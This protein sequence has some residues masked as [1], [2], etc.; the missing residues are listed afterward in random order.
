MT[1]K[2]IYYKSF[3]KVKNIKDINKTTV[4]LPNIVEND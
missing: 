3:Y 2:L 1:I 4:Q